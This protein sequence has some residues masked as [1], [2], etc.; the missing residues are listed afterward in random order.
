MPIDE[1]TGGFVPRPWKRLSDALFDVI[2]PDTNDGASPADQEWYTNLRHTTALAVRCILHGVDENH[3]R[4][5]G[6]AF[7]GQQLGQVRAYADMISHVFLGGEP[8]PRQVNEQL[9]R[10]VKTFGLV[11][12]D[13]APGRTHNWP[14]ATRRIT[15]PEAIE[16]ADQ[17]FHANYPADQGAPHGRPPARRRP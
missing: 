17:A 7:S 12:Y 11:V 6:Y 1:R 14:M 8:N 15:T 16:I 10:L 4:R 5:S 9:Q 13:P 2:P 3:S